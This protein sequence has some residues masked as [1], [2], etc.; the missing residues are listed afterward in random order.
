VVAAESA[1]EELAAAA[2]AAAAV[3]LVVGVDP[4]DKDLKPFHAR[5]GPAHTAR[6]APRPP[7]A[8][9][10]AARAP[11]SAAA[12]PGKRVVLRGA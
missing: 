9:W 8:R 10:Q 11:L 1:E 6:Q 4:S 3:G 12:P 2:G 5:C 7:L